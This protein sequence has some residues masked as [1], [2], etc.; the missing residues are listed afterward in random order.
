M[1][2]VGHESRGKL[3]AVKIRLELELQF[4]FV[5]ATVVEAIINWRTQ[6]RLAHPLLL[7]RRLSLGDPRAAASLRRCLHQVVRN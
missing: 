4:I 5:T 7:L 3:E 1:L 6:D 2:I